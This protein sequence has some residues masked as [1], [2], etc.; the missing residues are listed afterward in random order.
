MAV[1]RS[2]EKNTVFVALDGGKFEARTV[3]LGPRAGADSYQ[4]LSGLSEGDRIVTSGQFKLRTGMPVKI[5]NS[6]VPDANAN[7]H[8]QES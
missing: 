7:P 3:V 1:L 8:P 5:N 6:I 2:G 4:V